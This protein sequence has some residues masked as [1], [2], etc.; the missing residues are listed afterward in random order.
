M[1]SRAMPIFNDQ[2]AATLRAALDRIIPPDDYPGA[3]ENG[4]ERYILRQMTGDLACFVETYRAGLDGLEAEANA[5]YGGGF[6]SL[7]ADLQDVLLAKVELGE[8]S[9][10]WTVSPA[11]WFVLLACHAAEGYYSD[12]SNGGNIG[13]A[14]W[15]MVGF[16]ARR[17]MV[18]KA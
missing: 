6:A 2:Q 3:V 16:D 15:E 5:L 9:A 11:E 8:V 17:A 1:E 4:V 14:A 7:E 13:F 18:P 12:P 10:Q